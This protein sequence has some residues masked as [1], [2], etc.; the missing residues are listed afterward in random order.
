MKVPF[1]RLLPLLLA[2]VGLCS[3][4]ST[5][6]TAGDMDHYY[7][8]AQAK[9]DRII[10]HLG[11]MRDE[12]KISASEYDEKVKKTRDKVDQYAVE[13]AWTRHDNM[14]AVKRSLSIPTGDHPASIDAPGIG[15]NSDSFYRPAGSEG[16][17][18]QGMGSGMWHGYQA[19]STV[20]SL[21]GMFV[22]SQ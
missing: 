6:P 9:A 7:K 14:E 8:E 11:E 18:Y 22:R 19:G 16:Q 10:A 4:Q 5:T 2:M 12:G 13:M 20:D 1:S 15:G 21:N 17:G 3:C